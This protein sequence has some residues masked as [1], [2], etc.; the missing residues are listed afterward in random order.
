M[1][2]G[3]PFARGGLKLRVNFA[4]G[5]DDSSGLRFVGSEGVMTVSREVTLN[6]RPRPREF[7]YGHETFPKAMQEQLL[8]EYLAK[9]PDT[10]EQ[11]QS[12]TVEV[13]RQP[14]DYD[15]SERHFRNFFASIRSRAPLVEDA[16]FGLRAA[17]PAVLCNLSYFEN[18]PYAWDPEAMKAT[19]LGPAAC[20]GA[21]A[22]GSRS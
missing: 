1:Q 22:A 18:R 15:A 4:E 12:S 20:P 3:V 21:T 11:L 10:G 8:K 7:G 2:G 19:P 6:K 5:G 13:Y 14:R 16:V 9:Y 17:G